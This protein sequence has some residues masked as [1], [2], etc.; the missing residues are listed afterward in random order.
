MSTGDFL[1]DL[2]NTVIGPSERRFL[3]DLK[4]ELGLNQ[5]TTQRPIKK[6]PGSVVHPTPPAQR[7]QP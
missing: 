5:R 6:S 3:R 1:K 7:S 2:V 4:T